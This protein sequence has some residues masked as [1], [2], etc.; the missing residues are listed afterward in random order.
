MI[1]LSAAAKSVLA[2]GGYR[3]YRA[4]ESWRDG[5][6]L[7]ADVPVDTAQEETDRTLRVPERVTLTVPRQVAGESW[8]PN[9]EDSPLTA[10]GQRLHVKLGVGL[11]LGQVE[12]FARGRF[13]IQDSQ[14]R[15]DQV[16]VAAVGMLALVDEAKLV[17]PYQPT[18]GLIATLRGL[19]EPALT[20]LVDSGLTDR[21]PPAGINYDSDRLGAV[22]ELLDAWPADAAVDPEGFLSVVPAVQSMTP[23][24][25]L[26]DGVGG[27]VIRA[28]GGS[29][30]ADAANIVVA[31]GVASDGSQV[32][33][34][35][36]IVTGP[37]RAGGPFNPLPVPFFF[38]SPLLTSV[39]ECNAAA[40]TIA[41]R[42]R[43]ESAAAYRVEMVPHPGLQTGDVVSLTASDPPLSAVPCAVETLTLPYTTPVTQQVLTVRSL[44]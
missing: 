37:Q 12:W 7:A 31:R 29:T 3:Y 22:L 36:Q 17:S 44:S 13:L 38:S 10:A 8:A 9:R 42:K 35:A 6:L 43:R 40:A 32:Q 19:V 21:T 24:L 15:G 16:D 18:S 20:V 28:A 23:V 25:S 11:S 4:V 39:A 2:A 33:G 34:T 41:A 30:R 27:T 26:T 1:G 14:A 5:Q